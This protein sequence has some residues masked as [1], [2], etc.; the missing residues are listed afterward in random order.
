MQT[1]RNADLAA[2]LFL[3]C[4]GVVVLLSSS[5]IQVLPG[6]RLSPRTLPYLLGITVMICGGLIAFKAWRYHG[7][8]IRVKWPEKSGFMRIIVTIVS[9]AI[10]TALI[11]PIGMPI[12]TFLFIS[13][14]I[15][16]I[17][18]KYLV[19][20]LVTGAVTAVI[21]YYVFIILLELAF[22]LGPLG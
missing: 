8:A 9:L 18:R 19:T 6:E 11:D 21:V 10:Y 4:L 1:Q 14:L 15:W 5:T 2:G 20:A 7:V 13:F 3:V 12:A 17:E 16:F 22:P